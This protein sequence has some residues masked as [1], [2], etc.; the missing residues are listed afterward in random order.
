VS[1]SVVRVVCHRENLS[2]RRPIRPVRRCAEHRG[3]DRAVNR[4]PDR[5]VCSSLLPRPLRPQRLRWRR[6]HA[7]FGLR[8]ECAG[9]PDAEAVHAASGTKFLRPGCCRRVGCPIDLRIRGSLCGMNSRI[10]RRRTVWSPD[11]NSGPSSCG[12]DEGSPPR[13]AAAESRDAGIPS[14]EARSVENYAAVSSTAVSSRF[15]WRRCRR[16]TGGERR[17]GADDLLSGNRGRA[18]AVRACQGE[19]LA[20]CLLLKK[21]SARAIR[22]ARRSRLRRRAHRGHRISDRCFCEDLRPDRKAHH[23]DFT[24]GH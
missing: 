13:S 15:H 2:P 23:A 10:G 24:P 3:Q 22:P 21:L 11:R 9:R 1:T 18:H 7:A 17:P 4:R 6:L 8:G 19:T 20:S 16:G 5:P 14:G 12:T